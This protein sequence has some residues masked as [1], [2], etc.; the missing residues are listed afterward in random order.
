ME[1][2]AVN[3][4]TWSAEMGFNQGEI[5]SGQTRT[6][7]ISGQTSM[8][9]DGRPRNEGDMAAQVAL[10][11]DNMEAVLAEAGMS[12]ANLVRLNVYTTDVD[13]LFTHYG[14]LASRLT[15]AGV[16]PTTTMLGVVRL[17][18]PGQMVELEGTA[19]A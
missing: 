9:E 7:F 13:A 6:L 3:P 17:A 5:V 14:M 2:T 10:S 11:L 19:V 16:A 4:V 18:I 8:S 12:L 15:A 1:R